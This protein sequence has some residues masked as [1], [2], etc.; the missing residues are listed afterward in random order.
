M[1][2]I[3]M[4]EVSL[5]LGGGSV[6]QSATRSAGQMMSYLLETPD[7]RTVVIDGGDYTQQ[8]AERLYALLSE[9]GKRVDLWIITHA[10]EDHFGSLLW[11]LEHR[12]PFDLS[13]GEL[14]MDFPSLEWLGSME[15]RS[16]PHIAAFPEQVALHGIPTRTVKTGD[17][18]QAGALR[19]EIL[20]D[21]RDCTQPKTI[22]DTSLVIRTAFP[23]RDIL[24]LGDLGAAAAAEMLLTCDVRKLRCD[25]VQMA[26][27]GQDAAERNFYEAVRPKICLYTAPLWLWENDSGSGRGSGPWKTLETRGWMEALG[28]E[29]DYPMAWGDYLF[30]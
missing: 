5:G 3:K 25:I 29:A 6:L 10:H 21:A 26:H 22:N 15:P 9:R 20:H 27:H 4:N 30:R 11:L 28:R 24:F 7:G 23:A 16:L 2:A 1:D 14:C 19:M 17:L 8:N 12:D 13:I 18:L